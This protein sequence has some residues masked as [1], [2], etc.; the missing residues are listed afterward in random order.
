MNI[1]ASS[2]LSSAVLGVSIATMGL[3]QASAARNDDDRFEDNAR[4][5]FVNCDSNQSLRRA[6]R[7]VGP[8]GTVFVKGTCRGPVK[9]AKDGVSLV[10]LRRATIVGDQRTSGDL[11]GVITVDAARN[12]TIKGFTVKGGDFGIIGKRGA[13]FSVKR[14]RVEG[15]ASDGIVAI[16][17]STIDLQ[18]SSVT[19][20]G[21]DGIAITQ[22]SSGVF[23]GTIESRGNAD[24]GIVVADASTVDLST[25]TVVVSGNDD[26]GLIAGDDAVVITGSRGNTGTIIAEDNRGD[27]VFLF[28]AVTLEATGG[29]TIVAREND[30]SGMQLIGNAVI[31]NSQGNATFELHDNP[32]GLLLDVQSGVFFVG[33]LSIHDNKTGLSAS[34]ADTITA[35]SLPPNPIRIKDNDEDVVLSFGTRATFNNAEIGTISCDETVLSRGTTTCP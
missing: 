4:S 2:L 29:G 34:G 5:V 20:A 14:C 10:G 23:R 7:R 6:I 19:D 17:N 31:V 33:G 22:A 13:V 25:A 26:S 9:L 21:D 28:N 27:G 16:L 11:T 32:V 18:D 35:I 1:Q 30:R 8:G 24:D 15:S 12:V 3:S